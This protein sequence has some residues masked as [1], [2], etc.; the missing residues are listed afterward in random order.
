MNCANLKQANRG[1]VAGESPG[2]PANQLFF[3]AIP[4]CDPGDSGDSGDSTYPALRF[5][6]RPCSSG[7]Q[8]GVLLSSSLRNKRPGLSGRPPCKGVAT[9]WLGWHASSCQ[10]VRRSRRMP[11]RQPNFGGRVQF[12]DFAPPFNGPC[13][14]PGFRQTSKR[15]FNC[16]D[17]TA[18]VT[19]ITVAHAPL[20]TDDDDERRTKQDGRQSRSYMAARNIPPL[21]WADTGPVSW[22][23]PPLARGRRVAVNSSGG[24]RPRGAC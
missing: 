12:R 24:R 11:I 7:R 21:R 18:V 20:T 14:S 19:R 23:P 17:K 9:Y 13:S 10:Q 16:D 1:G 22:R 5:H 15:S 8:G 4:F 6:V 3:G 2:N